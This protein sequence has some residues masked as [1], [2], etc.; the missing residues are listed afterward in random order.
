MVRQVRVVQ[1]PWGGKSSA[2]GRGWACSC[3]S[4]PRASRSSVGRLVRFREGQGDSHGEPMERPC[5]RVWGG[6]CGPWTFGGH[7][8]VSCR[9]RSGMALSLVSAE[10]FDGN[11]AVDEGVLSPAAP[12]SGVL[13]PPP[14]F[15]A[16]R[17]LLACE[18]RFYSDDSDALLSVVRNLRTFHHFWPAEPEADLRS[19]LCE[20]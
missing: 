10:K 7:V 9:A 17:R 19:W 20:P 18:S 6:M 2:A 13:G 4:G 14:G 11:S 15:S 3:D 16:L 8:Q 1:R 12:E 5:S